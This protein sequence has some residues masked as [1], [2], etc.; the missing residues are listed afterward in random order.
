MLA[1]PA[2]CSLC[3]VMLYIHGHAHTSSPVSADNA[4]TWYA[5]CCVDCTDFG[6]FYQDETV[7]WLRNTGAFR[8]WRIELEQYKVTVL[9]QFLQNRPRVLRS[10][11]CSVCQVTSASWFT[12]MCSWLQEIGTAQTCF[13]IAV[14][15]VFCWK[16]KQIISMGRQQ[17]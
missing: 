8:H 1:P 3:G 9:H 16:Q 10:W 13:W 2:L 6:A 4:D 15:T 14:G 17:I 12:I 11:W 5:L 7:L